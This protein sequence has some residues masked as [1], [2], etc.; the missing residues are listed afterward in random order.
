[1]CILEGENIIP[2]GCHILLM[3]IDYIYELEYSQ[4]EN[5]DLDAR[6][7]GCSIMFL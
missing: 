3:C 7:V 2:L 1:M 5:Y 6:T 4:F